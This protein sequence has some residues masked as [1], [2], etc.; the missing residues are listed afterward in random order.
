[1]LPLLGKLIANDGDSYRYLAESIRMH[2]DQE[3]LKK[4]IE[5]A[6]FERVEYFNL[7]AGVVALHRGYK[8]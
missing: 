4:L 5:D 6:G 2:P 7:S 3:Q 1:M 8:L